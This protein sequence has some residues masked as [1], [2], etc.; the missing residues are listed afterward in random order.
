MA[1]SLLNHIQGKKGSRW[2]QFV[3]DTGSENLLVV[4]ID[5]AK[6]T[7]KV[8]IC[9]FYGDVLVKPFE[10]DASLSGFE[11]VKKQIQLEKDKHGMQDVVVGIETTGHYYEDLVRR[12][13]L[14]GFHVR[15][16]NSATTAQERDALLNW[17]K[18]DN[19]DLMAIVQSIIHG[20]G[21]SNE[22]SSGNVHT[23]QK[24]TRARRELVDERT[25]TQN[26]IRMHIDHIFREFQGKSVWK[27][28]KREHCQ[29]FSKLF[30]KAP[31]YIM[32]HHPHPSD[33]L[34]LGE[35]WLR[36]LSIR[37]NLKLR[38]QS[39]KTLLEFAKESISQPKKYVEADIFLLIQKLDRLELLDHQIKVLER[40]IEDLFIETEGAVILTV[41]GI[42]VVTGAEFFAEMGDISDF[43][44]A[45]Q[46]IK[47]AGTNPIVK[48]SG[49]HK[50]TYY[51][52]S[53]QGRRTFRNI[54]YQVGKSLAV[55]NPEMKQRYLDL[56]ERGKHTRQAYVALGNRMIR[57]A[58]SMIRNRTL[59]STD[60]ENY[61]LINEL[62]KKLRAANVKKFYEQHISST[63]C[64]SA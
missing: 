27:N 32:R 39:I 47:L 10:F 45:G 57:L 44:H 24:L 51:G 30:G 8:L 2:A 14:E 23:L 21:T 6:F 18:T 58:F 55:N 36:A 28:G 4:A 29:P 43:D 1:Y 40:K 56:K 46:L 42:G 3:R 9:T 16:V 61:V 48:Q 59:Y 63:V 34:A 38:D 37:E 17:S 25:A 19:L 31:R 60:Q 35:D 20:R 33:I 49:G 52:I 12:C 50:P 62:S 5:A 15:I 13:H 53:K 11:R 22:L 64:L 7:H 41:P 54:T 26:L